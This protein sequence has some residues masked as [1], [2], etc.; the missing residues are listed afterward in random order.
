MPIIVFGRLS[1]PVFY[2]VD[3]AMHIGL[4]LLGGSVLCVLCVNVSCLTT[5]AVTYAGYK[6]LFTNVLVVIRSLA[7]PICSTLLRPM[8]TTFVTKFYQVKG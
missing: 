5:F 8:V 7:T 6:V 2:C 3:G 4:L 1:A